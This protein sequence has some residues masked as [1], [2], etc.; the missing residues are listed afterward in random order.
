MNVLLFN[1]CSDNGP[2]TTGRKLS[3]YLHQ[4][5]VARGY[6]VTQINVSEGHIPF[7]S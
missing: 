3:A 1:G 4:Q 6:T 5:L 2:E 7:F